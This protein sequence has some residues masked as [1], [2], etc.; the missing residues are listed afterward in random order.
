VIGSHFV[1]AVVAEP[2]LFVAVKV[3]VCVP[4]TT[5]VF[6]MIAGDPAPEPT[7]SKRRTRP[8]RAFT[9]SVTPEPPGTGALIV[10]SPCASMISCTVASDRHRGHVRVNVFDQLTQVE[11]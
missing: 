3:A 11:L 5:V 8:Q 7:S 10:I 9:V 4:T 1:G 6:A 2:G